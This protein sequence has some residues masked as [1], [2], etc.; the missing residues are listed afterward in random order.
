MDRDKE[1]KLNVAGW[2]LFV[3]SA[4]FFIGASL[5]TGDILG[6]LGGLFFFVA[7]FLFLAPL[8]RRAPAGEG[9]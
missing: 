2:I 8:T 9:D 6:L 1:R 3:I 5:R 7:C 4:L